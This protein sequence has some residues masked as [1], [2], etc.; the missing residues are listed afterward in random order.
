MLRKRIV[1]LLAAGAML[2]GTL[3][4]CGNSDSGSKAASTSGSSAKTEA[5]SASS[6]SKSSSSSAASGTSGS[7]AKGGNDLISDYASYETVEAADFI[8]RDSFKLSGDVSKEYTIA[9][10]AGNMGSAYFYAG[11]TETQKY[12]ESL[13][14]K[15]LISDADADLATQVNQIEN[16]ITQGVDAIIINVVDPPSGVSEALQKAADAG[17]PVAAVDSMLDENFENYLAFIGSDNYA[18]GFSCGVAAANHLVELYGEVKGTCGVFDGVEGNAVAQLIYDG[19]WDG[20]ASIQEDHKLEEVSHLYGGAW[21]EE[22]GLQMAEDMLV[23]NEHID[24]MFAISDPFLMGALTACERA[25]RSEMFMCGRDGDKAALKAVKDGTAVKFIAGQDPVG[26][27]IIATDLVLSHLENGTLPEARIL[28]L[29]P[30]EAGVDNIDEV[31]DPD[32]AF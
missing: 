10:V 14:C 16:F 4:G 30:I 23:A 24:I 18:L 28:R 6:E 22:A 19:F 5:Q 7:E 29:A 2:T 11:P 13:G 17:I 26:M 31:Y 15:C 27:G 25:G 8:S 20:V 9:Y 1:A 21:T 32:A 3:A 12:I